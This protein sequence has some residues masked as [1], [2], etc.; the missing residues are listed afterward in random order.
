MGEALTDDQ[1][2]AAPGDEP[3]DAVP[4]GPRPEGAV[5]EGAP[6][7]PPPGG[8]TGGRRGPFAGV[9]AHISAMPTG[10]LVQALVSLGIVAACVVFTFVQLGPGNIFSDTTP[11]GG[12]MGAHVWG[13]AYLRDHLL[14]S[15]RLVGWTSDWYAGFPAYQFYM[16]APAVAIAALSYVVPYGTAFKLVVVAGVLALPVTAWAF[17]R[18]TRLPFPVSPL[19]AVAATMFLFDRSYSILGGNLAS[20]FAGEFS[21]SIALSLAVLYLGVLGRGLETGKHR[22]WAAL[23]LALVALTHPIVLVLAVM[24]TVVWFLLSLEWSRLAPAVAVPLL[25]ASFGVGA[26]AATSSAAVEITGWWLRALVFGGVLAVVALAVATMV[27]AF[28]RAQLVYLCTVGPVAAALSAF[29]TIPFL[30]RA[31]YMNDMGWERINDFSAL[32]FTRDGDALAGL[33][34][35]GV[36]APAMRWILVLAIAGAL[37]AVVAAVFDRNR[38]ALLFVGTAVLAGLAFVLVPQGRLWNARLLPFY[39][40]SL[41]FLGAIGV[42]YVARVLAMLVARDPAKPVRAVNVTA[43]V[44]ATVVGIVALAMPLRAMP[45]GESR[46]G[47]YHWAFL[48]TTDS[49]FIPSWARWNFEGFEGKPAYPEYQ[50]IVSTMDDLGQELGCGRAMWEHESE[51]NRYGT[52]MALMLLPFWTDGCIGS[53]EG[54]YFEAAATTPYHFINQDELSTAPSNPQRDLPYGP[55]PPSEAEF[56]RGV[57]HLQML[58][59]K[60]YLAIS[61]RMIELGRADPDLVEVASSGPWV[62]FEVLDSE[63]VSPLANEPAVLT[64]TEG[65]WLDQTIDW[66]VSPER[67]D[68]HLAQSGPSDWPRVAQGEVPERVPLPPVQVSG[69]EEGTDT[70]SFDVDQV[71]VPVLV[72]TS[73]FPNWQVSGADGPWRV[74]PNLMVVVPTDTHVELSYGW[75]SVD[76]AGWGLAGLGV[77]G[78]VLLA[79]ARPVAMPLRLRRADPDLDEPEGT[80]VVERVDRDADADADA[81]GDGAAG[82]RDGSAAVPAA[83]FDPTDV[84]L[85]EPADPDRPT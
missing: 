6:P 29:W 18:L 79:V 1:R 45:F 70:I 84:I 60:Y 46:G 30:L 85:G 38:N 15:G 34:S 43:A 33:G 76:L 4:D 37:M 58:G 51:H 61:D 8:P 10:D 74:S 54:L 42:A 50:G 9:A 69:I 26:L 20:T 73:Y 57:A 22:A 19:L 47:E 82:A 2:Q 36:D 63:L 72:K 78:L 28:P 44:A 31:G 3:G 24:G 52:P 81:D 35:Q 5:P 67:W 39:Y 55:G 12:D 68:V 59:V 53:M 40:L 14:P 56:E 41:Y 83:E 32:L 66:Y 77:V 65:G 64:D 62:V 48:S 17:G 11:A 13:P 75:T 16:V 7:P 71:G 49:S 23:L 25:V 21:F 80:Y 27:A